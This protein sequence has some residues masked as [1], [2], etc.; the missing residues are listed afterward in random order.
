MV[1]YR[2][3]KSPPTAPNL[4]QINPVHAPTSHFLKIHPRLSLQVVFFF[5]EVLPPPPKKNPA[6]LSTIRTTYPAH[7]KARPRVVD[8]GTASNMEGSCK[9]IEKAVPDSRQWV[10][11][12]FG[13]LGEVLKTHYR[14]SGIVKKYTHMLRTWNNT[15]VRPKQFPIYS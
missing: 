15:S 5:P 9:Y 12:Q 1:H 14:E 4:N 11:L 7:R 10:F 6:L 8:R 13:E 3:H 2:I